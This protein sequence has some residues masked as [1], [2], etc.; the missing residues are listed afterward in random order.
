MKQEVTF[1]DLSGDMIQDPSNTV[2]LNVFEHPDLVDGQAVRLEASPEEVVDIEKLAIKAVRVEVYR[3]DD[4]EPV[5]FTM[6]PANFKKLATGKPMNEVLANAEPLKKVARRAGAA[7]VN[8]A[9]VKINFSDPENSGRPHKGKTSPQEAYYVKKNLLKVNERNAQLGERLVNPHHPDH[10]K[11]YGLDPKDYPEESMWKPAE[12]PETPT[13][14][15]EPAQ[16]APAE[17]K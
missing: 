16:E 2:A 15:A 1:S 5:M 14:P 10:Q 7:A 9:E 4:E 17:A 8:G 11:R 3:P 6:T 12:E 13:V